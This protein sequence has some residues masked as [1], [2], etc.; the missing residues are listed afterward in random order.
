MHGGGEESQVVAVL[1][2]VMENS[3]AKAKRCQY[4]PFLTFDDIARQFG[5]PI[6]AGDLHDNLNKDRIPSYQHDDY[7]SLWRRDRKSVV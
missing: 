3:L 1:H 7:A 4:P 6:A 2:D 5:A